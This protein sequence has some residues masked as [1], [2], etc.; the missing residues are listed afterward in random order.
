MNL[1][2]MV[3]TAAAVV[4]L[5]GCPNTVMVP[6]DARSVDCNTGP[7]ARCD[8]AIRAGTKYSCDV[9]RFDV[10]PDYIA[11]RGGRPVNMFWSLPDG[12]AFCGNDGVYLANSLSAEERQVIESFGSNNSDGSR[13][14]NAFVAANC[15]AS[16]HWNYRNQGAATYKY[17]IQFTHKASGRKCVIDPFIKNG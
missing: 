13:E 8:I 6:A 3:L 5:A 4:A 2:T 1:R 11:L 10:D 17:G 7:G 14:S 15:S 16:W 9:G 12:F